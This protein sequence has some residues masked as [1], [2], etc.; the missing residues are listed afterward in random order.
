MS[1]PSFV[2]EPQVQYLSTLLDEVG[3][4]VLQVPRFQRPFLWREERR[5]ELLRSIRDG[6]PIGAI[7]VWRTTR[8][9][10]ACYDNLGPHILSRPSLGE[11]AVRQYLL[12]GVQRLSTLYD[13]LYLPKQISAKAAQFEEMH[14]P[15]YFDLETNDFYFGEID[16]DV[17]PNLMPLTVL[18]DG[19]R[20]LKFQRGIKGPRQD[21]WIDASDQLAN[22]FRTYKLAVLPI[23]TD[24]IE[25][26]TRTFQRINSQVTRMGEVHM[27]HALSWSEEF[28]LLQRME[29]FKRERLAPLGWQALDDD[30]IVDACKAAYGLDVYK[31]EAEDLAKELRNNP[32]VLMQ[33]ED[34]ITKAAVFLRDRCGVPSVEFVPYQPQMLLLAE[35]FRILPELPESILNLLHSWFWLTTYSELF[36]GMSDDRMRTTL[37]YMRETVQTKVLRWPGA[38]AFSRAPLS[39]RWDFRSARTKALALRLAALNPAQPEGGRASVQRLLADK[40]QAAL[41]PLI[42]RNWVGTELY[43]NPGNRFLVAP[44]EA[45][46]LL[47][48][49]I[50]DKDISN[51]FLDSHAIPRES[52]E[53]LRKRKFAEF[54]SARYDRL[55]AVEVEFV[56][57]FLEIL[58]AS[59]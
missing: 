36:R 33:V 32:T 47:N 2:S 58:E 52:L 3:K 51:E 50:V 9:G 4:G 19:V 59:S 43:T 1:T 31:S 12:D 48:K 45:E 56:G 11:G 57:D 55:D 21:E 37:N 41:C 40:Q 18:F 46:A 13:A 5:Q 44:E 29:D 26:A 30:W 54:I 35:A 27:V 10:I 38:R 39:K 20:L 49:L 42:P 25:M 23:V 53:H 34:A 22:A 8:S 7:M 24:D 17:P 6:I 15:A 14:L 28:D 16:E